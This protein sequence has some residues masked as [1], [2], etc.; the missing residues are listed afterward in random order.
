M[1]KK[2]YGI[3]MQGKFRAQVLTTLP[4]F[5]NADHYRLLVYVSSQNKFY[6]GLSDG[7]LNV[8]DT[9]NAFI[10]PNITLDAGQSAWLRTSSEKV[11]IDAVADQIRVYDDYLGIGANYTV[12]EDGKI[13]QFVYDPVTGTPIAYEPITRYEEGTAAIGSIVS[14]PGYW[15]EIPNIVLTPYSIDSYLPRYPE[16]SQRMGLWPQSIQTQPGQTKKYQFY[17]G[18]QIDVRS[19]ASA[20]KYIDDTF[21]ENRSYLNKGYVYSKFYY[22]WPNVRQLAAV[23][24]GSWLKTG[25]N[26]TFNLGLEYWVDGVQQTTIWNGPFIGSGS[27]VNGTPTFAGQIDKFRV[28]IEPLTISNSAG[29]VPAIVTLD[30]YESTYGAISSPITGTVKWQAIGR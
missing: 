18:G 6:F 5:N 22:P 17:V 13:Y 16:Q 19:R 25:V 28:L 4:T 26:G 15:R 29:D 23:I 10:K 9:N 30:F 3:D 2:F 7:W 14:I 8:G 20:R 24:S 21:S 1:E 12:L 27:E 11:I